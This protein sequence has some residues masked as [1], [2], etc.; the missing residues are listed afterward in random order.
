MGKV[1]VVSIGLPLIGAILISMFMA[2]ITCFTEEQRSIYLVL[3]EG[4]DALAF[5]KHSSTMHSNRLI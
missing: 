2:A 3:M 5:T 4:D 1:I